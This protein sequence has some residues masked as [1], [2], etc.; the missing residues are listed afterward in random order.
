[1]TDLSPVSELRFALTVNDFDAALRFYRDALGLPEVFAWTHDR[2]RGAVLAAGRATV[3]LLSTSQSEYVDSVEVGRRIAGPVRLAIEVTDADAVAEQL[4]AAGGDRLAAPV[5]TPWGHRNIRLRAPDGLQLTLFTAGR[6][7]PSLST[8]DDDAFVAQAIDLAVANVAAGQL[9]FGAVVVLDTEVVGTGVNTV[10]GDADPT[11]H[12]EV[13]A[14]RDACRR[15]GTTR[16][17]G[18]V[19][20]SSAEPCPMCQEL[21][22]L[23]GIERVAYAAPRRVAAGYGFVLP[24]DPATVFEQAPSAD[25][26]EPFLRYAEATSG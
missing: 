21:C 26:D 1:M 18:A 9:P 25:A 4:E 20:V 10:A 19:V 15:L 16:L 17:P 6:A 11:A 3:E 7:T 12:A 2:G 8:H 14:I 5:L 24:A 13:A 23:V 22:R